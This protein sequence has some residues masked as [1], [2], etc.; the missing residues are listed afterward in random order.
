MNDALARLPLFASDHEIAVAIVGKEKASYYTKA[1]IP[2]LERQSFP[3]VDPLHDGRP[4]QLVQQFYAA[5]LGMAA[6]SSVSAPDGQE[7]MSV[8]KKSVRRGSG[9]SSEKPAGRQPG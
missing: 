8:W 6:G 7:D 3:R 1:V 2:M 9:G 5:Y 4:V